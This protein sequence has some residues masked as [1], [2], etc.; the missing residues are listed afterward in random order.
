MKFGLFYHLSVLKPWTNPVEQ[1]QQVFREALEQVQLADELGFHSVW[2]VEHHFLEEFSHS[3]APEVFLAACAGR[4]QNIRLGHGIVC[5]LPPMNH[6]ARVAE[7]AASLDQVSGGRLEFGTGRSS[8]WTEVGGFMVDPDD[9]KPMWDESLRAIPK[10]WTQDVFSHEGKY[11]SMPPRNVLPKPYQKPHPPLWVAVMSPETVQDAA[12]RGLGML[13]LSFGTP[14]QQHQRVEDYRKRI[15]DCEPVGDFVN[16]QVFTT[17]SLFCHEDDEAGYKTASQAMNTYHRLSGQTVTPK[18]VY[19]GR[20][21]R[22]LGAEFYRGPSETKEI[23]AI[24]RG[25]AAVGDPHHIIQNIKKWE[26]V[27]VD[28]LI[29]SISWGT[30]IEQEQ[31]LNSLRLFAK[32]VMPHFAEKPAAKVNGAG[33]TPSKSGSVPLKAGR[34]PAGGRK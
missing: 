12:E 9:T 6:P 13:G 28:G 14:D 27:G 31:V 20:G 8:T 25:G 22:H 30:A 32:E 5:L 10:M 33:V 1:T 4:T 15:K 18:Q 19:P 3:S 29:F 24:P 2:A 16:E 34:Q 21:Y 17:C 23:Q 7:R 26:D 11:F